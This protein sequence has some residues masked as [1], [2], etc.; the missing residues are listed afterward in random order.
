[1]DTPKRCFFYFWFDT[2]SNT[3]LGTFSFDNSL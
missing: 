2:G 3:I 1:M